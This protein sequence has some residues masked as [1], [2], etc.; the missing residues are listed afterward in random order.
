MTGTMLKKLPETMKSRSDKE[1]IS[2]I[3]SAKKR[4]CSSQ[5]ESS[6]FLK[7]IRISIDK[8][9]NVKVKPI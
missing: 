3:R 7:R 8:K 1:L 2:Q 9:G 5:A 4:I 6:A